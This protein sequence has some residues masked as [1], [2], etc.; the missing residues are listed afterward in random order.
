M[1]EN[2]DKNFNFSFIECNSKVLPAISLKIK[3][4][5]VK[6]DEHDFQ[7]ISSMFKY[8]NIWWEKNNGIK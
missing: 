6:L 4:M 5:E 2:N 7:T 3:D 1:I 8:W